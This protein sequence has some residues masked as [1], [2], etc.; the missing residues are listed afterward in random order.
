MLLSKERTH[1]LDIVTISG[2]VPG[3]GELTAV[4]DREKSSLLMVERCK[5]VEADEETVDVLVHHVTRTEEKLGHPQCL[6]L[7]RNTEL[8][9]LKLI[10]LD[11]AC[12]DDEIEF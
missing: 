4:M 5:K 12:M 1:I 7:P 9:Q 10:V 6:T 2:H 11:K 3:K 8:A